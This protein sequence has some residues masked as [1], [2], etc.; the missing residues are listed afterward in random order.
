MSCELVIIKHLVK[1]RRR[2]EPWAKSHV[3]KFTKSYRSWS[4]TTDKPLVWFIN[5]IAGYADCHRNKYQ[6]EIGEDG[7]LGDGMKGII[8]GLRTLLNGVLCGLDGGEMDKLICGLA[9][10]MKVDLSE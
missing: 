6:S 5:A 8:E 9:E 4:V 7:V 3:D 2:E 1:L 10:E